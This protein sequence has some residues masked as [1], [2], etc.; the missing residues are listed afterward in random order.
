MYISIVGFSHDE[1]DTEE[2]V[3]FSIEIYI[4]LLAEF[5]LKMFFYLFA[6]TK[7]DKIINIKAE[8]DWWMILE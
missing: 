2:I 3:Y 7:I 1:I 8:V 5:G 4:Y 6:F